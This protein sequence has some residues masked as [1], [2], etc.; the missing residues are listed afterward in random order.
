MTFVQTNTDL[1]YIG[2]VF[3]IIFSV[4][5]LFMPFGTF[6][7]QRIFNLKNPFNYSII[8]LVLITVSLVT[9]LLNI[10]LSAT[11]KD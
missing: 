4:A 6:F 11:T 9:L 8:G 1:N 7:F 2:R 10:A 3:G 5:I